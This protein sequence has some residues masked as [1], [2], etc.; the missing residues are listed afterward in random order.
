MVQMS[1]LWQ[2]VR[3]ALD[4]ILTP[5]ELEHTSMSIVAANNR[6]V[7][8]QVI[9]EGDVLLRIIVHNEPLGFWLN[10]Q[11]G[12]TAFTARLRS[13]LQDFVAESSFGWGQLRS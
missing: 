8:G 1:E 6:P 13:D 3:P 10:P 5:T 12:P 4:A 2:A 7:M 9:P 11:E